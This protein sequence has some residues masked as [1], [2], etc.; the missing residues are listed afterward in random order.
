MPVS[1]KLEE[2]R[3][4]LFVSVG[5]LSLTYIILMKYHP[6][7]WDRDLRLPGISHYP[8]QSS[9]LSLDKTRRK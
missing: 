7:T 4:N 5:E 2:D 3:E 1:G 6:V 9:V 8:L